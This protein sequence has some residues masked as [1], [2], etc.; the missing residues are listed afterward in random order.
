MRRQGA[1]QGDIGDRHERGLGTGEAASAQ[2]F[3]EALARQ[4]D[5]R[6]GGGEDRLH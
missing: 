5:D 6:I 2:V 3:R 4:P 1:D